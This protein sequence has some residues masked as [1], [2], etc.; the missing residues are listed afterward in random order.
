[1][2]LYP[3]IFEQVYNRTKKSVPGSYEALLV[4][5][6]LH[7]YPLVHKIRSLQYLKINIKK[8]P[9]RGFYIFICFNCIE[10]CTYVHIC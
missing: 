10:I 3:F 2:T 5:R 7:F 4:N 8:I 1:M 6:T 9:K